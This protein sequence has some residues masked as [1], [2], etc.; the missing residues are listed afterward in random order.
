MGGVK[1][2]HAGDT[3]NIPEM[4]ELA[5]LGIDVALLPVSGV[6]VMTPEEAAEAVKMIKPRMAVPM[7]YGSIVGSLQEA[8]RFKELAS[9]ITEVVVLEK[10][11]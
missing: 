9:G 3:D 7:H 2:Y 1:I 8:E 5:D 6:Y 11:S 10:L 4:A